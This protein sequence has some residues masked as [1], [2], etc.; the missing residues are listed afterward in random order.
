[1]IRYRLGIPVKVVGAPL[2]AY[3]SRRWP[4]QPHLSVSLAYLRDLFGYLHQHGIGL[5][6]L[7]G[8][9][10]PYLTHPD[11]PQ[12]HRQLEECA[13]E[14]AALGDLARQCHLRLTLHPA[15]FV[16]L[17]SPDPAQVKRAY[18]ELSAAAALLDS[19]GL[20]SEAVIVVH[21]GSAF[22]AAVAGRARFVAAY[23][24][25]PPA[26]RARLALENDDRAYD[27]QDLQWIHKRTG[28][29][30]VL[31]VLHHRCYNSARLPTV[32]ALSLALASW[33]PGE[34]PK[35]HFSSPRTELRRSIRK[36]ELH[37]QLPL[38]NQHSDFIHPFEFI[39]FMQEARQAGLPAFD[40]ML[41][42]KAK[43]LALVRLREQLARYAPE[44]AA[45]VG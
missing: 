24:R 34:Q 4:Q 12:F 44:L 31:D 33:P 30:L 39:D 25:L 26:V 21:V 6:R 18:T 19:M 32:E 15:F 20:G 14:L 37:L 1:M 9:L 16:Q 3:D 8:Q 13:T 42:A 7:A 41:E 10:A 36:G 27:I 23:D 2:R 28:V 45:V 40:I 29:R 22:G 5:Y 11:L 35:I 43:E 38:P 17:N